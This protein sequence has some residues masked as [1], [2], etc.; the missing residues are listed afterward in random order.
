MHQSVL[1]EQVL[2]AFEGKEIN[3]FVDGTVGAGGHSEALLLAHPEITRFIGIDQ[4]P[5]A[6]KI[7]EKRLSLFRLQ[8]DPHPC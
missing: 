2:K 8:S 6:L 4:D 5:A 3:T 7:A 1:L